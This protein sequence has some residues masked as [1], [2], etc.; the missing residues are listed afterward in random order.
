MTVPRTSPTRRQSLLHHSWAAGATSPE[1]ACPQ[2]QQQQQPDV[3]LPRPNRE[4]RSAPSSASFGRC[5]PGPT[6]SQVRLA[7]AA[8]PS[9]QKN[10]LKLSAAYRVPTPDL[11]LRLKSVAMP[12]SSLHRCT[13]CIHHAH[14]D[15][16]VRAHLH[17][18]DRPIRC[19]SGMAMKACRGP[20]HRCMCITLCI[21][22]LS[23]HA[24]AYACRGKRSTAV[25]PGA[26]SLKHVMKWRVSSDT[27]CDLLKQ[28][29][30]RIG[31]L[32]L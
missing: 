10:V 25:A 16:L 6:L 19:V 13:A 1:L 14:A 24:A 12:S 5:C 30:L 2:K 23:H 26:Q 7:N 28:D 27:C 15:H 20:R 4:A 8:S 29:K 17:C 32:F 31:K 11:M 21:W 3:E 22:D 9:R 18:K